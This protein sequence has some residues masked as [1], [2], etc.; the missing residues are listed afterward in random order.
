M[1][2]EI[3]LIDLYINNEVFSNL[4]QEVLEERKR[5]VVQQATRLEAI[6]IEINNICRLQEKIVSK[7]SQLHHV[8]GAGTSSG[9]TLNYQMMKDNMIIANKIGPLIYEGY[10]LTSK[11]LQEL[12]IINPVDY[13]FTYNGPSGFMR[14]K[15]LYID[16]QKDLTYE[17]HRGA[18]II[19]LKES[20][21]KNKIL[22]NQ[23]S[24]NVAWVAEH[25]N[26]FMKPLQEAESKGKFK[27]NQGIASEAFE[28]HWEELQHQ[29]EHENQDD[30]G[31]IGKIWYLYRISSG[32]D[33]YYTGPDTATSQV[34]NVNASIISNADT[35]L[36]TIQ[37]VLKLVY[38]K[39]SSVEEA[40]SLKNQY[41]QSFTQKTAETQKI[42]R[43]IW[44]SVDEDIQKMIMQQFK[45]K[46]ATLTKK[47]VIFKT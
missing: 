35:V 3:N 20:N 38:T 29:I 47:F 27:I 21:I 23:A 1:A 46:D 33:P 30:F 2:A 14:A 40:Q 22:E 12:G 16:P 44:D 41:A 26:K 4:S 10:I 17:V 13:T 7:H 15:N 32:N 19:R 6:K 25:Y 11:I 39:T 43:D 18:L 42:S 36:N 31:G 34:K 45:A 5:L 8:L 9:L 28:R 37:A 24:H